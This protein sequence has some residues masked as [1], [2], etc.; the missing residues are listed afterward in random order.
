MNDG[1][2]VW[3]RD[4]LF[5]DMPLF[6]SDTQIYIMPNDRSVDI[7]DELDFYLAELLA[8]KKTKNAP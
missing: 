3:Q 4:A 7:D 5:L 6:N 1:I 8:I 2:Y